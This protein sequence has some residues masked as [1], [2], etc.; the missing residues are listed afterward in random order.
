MKANKG[1][2]TKL[3]QPVLPNVLFFAQDETGENTAAF[4]GD[5]SGP[6][7]SIFARKR[8]PGQSGKLSA[9]DVMNEHQESLNQAAA[10]AQNVLPAELTQFLEQQQSNPAI[11]GHAAMPDTGAILGQISL[12]TSTSSAVRGV[13]QG[14]GVGVLEQIANASSAV[15]A[16]WGVCNGTGSGVAATMTGNGTGLLVDHNGMMGNVAVFRSGNANRARI[17]KMGRGF[18]NG[19]TQNSGADVAEAFQVEGAVLGKA[20]ENF[21]GQGTGVIRVLV[22]VK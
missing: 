19:G 11:W 7:P 10:D 15:P 8:P 1:R 4:F 2:R 6:R 22:N 21:D 13:H 9:T 18:F 12:T 17:D 14:L 20:L 3:S 5:V 16:V